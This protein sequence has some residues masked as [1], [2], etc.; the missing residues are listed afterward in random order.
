MTRTTQELSLVI[1]SALG[2]RRWEIAMP[3]SNA[4]RSLMRRRTIAGVLSPPTRGEAPMR[5]VGAAI[6][7]RACVIGWGV[8]NLNCP[9]NDI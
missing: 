6:Q 5:F 3:I 7:G 2:I 1:S 9:S 4:A 8:G